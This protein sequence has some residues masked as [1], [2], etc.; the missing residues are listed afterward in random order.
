MFILCNSKS[1]YC[2]Y[3]VKKL[4]IGVLF[5]FF[6]ILRKKKVICV[7]TIHIYLVQ[8]LNREEETFCNKSIKIYVHTYA[9]SY[10]LKKQINFEYFLWHVSSPNF[11]RSLANSNKISLC[12]NPLFMNKY[13][14]VLPYVY[15]EST[16]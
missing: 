16:L 10:M 1:F 8:I 3:Q 6:S 12:V 7:H 13:M 4:F 14:S 15:G 11:T 9:H 5:D 2:E